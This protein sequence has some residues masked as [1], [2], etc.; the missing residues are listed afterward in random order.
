MEDAEA[1][2][3]LIFSECVIAFVPSSSLTPRVIGE[4]SLR[5]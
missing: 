3:A 4:V 2:V 1:T 5:T